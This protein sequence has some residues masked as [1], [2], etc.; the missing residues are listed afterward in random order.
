MYTCRAKEGHHTTEEFNGAIASMIAFL[1]TRI[2]R[3][4][5]LDTTFYNRNGRTK[6]KKTLMKMSALN[7]QCN[8]AMFRFLS[9]HLPRSKMDS[10]SHPG[11]LTHCSS[12]DSSSAA[13]LCTTVRSSARRRR[14]T[15]CTTSRLVL[16][17]ALEN[18]PALTSPTNLGA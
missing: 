5:Y 4:V 2:P 15:S 6:G 10:P 9:G 12:R 1:C 18:L 17:E 8:R 7:Q 14:E 13:S 16:R 3:L 11:D